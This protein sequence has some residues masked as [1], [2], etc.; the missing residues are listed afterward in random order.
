VLG[1]CR[2]VK[3]MHTVRKLPDFQRAS[4]PTVAGAIK[5]GI[6][7]INSRVSMKE[8]P[9]FGDG[10]GKVHFDATF[11]DDVWRNGLG[12]DGFA[13]MCPLA[14]ASTY[15]FF[16]SIF[17]YEKYVDGAEL[18]KP[19]MNGSEFI[20]SDE[21]KDNALVILK[22]ALCATK[23]IFSRENTEE[24]E[25]SLNERINDSFGDFCELLSVYLAKSNDSIA[26]VKRALA[27]LV[28]ENF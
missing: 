7:T 16:V 21:F 19:E 1:R 14:I 10:N 25:E 26:P 24:C 13:G 23:Q 20:E 28:D 8:M 3:N 2:V 12:V 6:L 9:F 17:G 22:T 15:A 11:G 4:L 27:K 18:F 5:I